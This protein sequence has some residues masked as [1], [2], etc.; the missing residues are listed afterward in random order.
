MADYETRPDERLE[1]LLRRWGAD[2]VVSGADVSG[3]PA[4]PLP[5]VR[6]GWLWRWMPL[7]A[8]MVLVAGA[9]SIF[10]ASHES[11]YDAAPA[12]RASL[13]EG[14]QIETLRAEAEQLRT[15]LAVAK[16]QLAA[17][18][19]NPSETAKLRA[20]LAKAK[21]QLEK[22]EAELADVTIRLYGKEN[23]GKNGQNVAA[24]QADLRKARSTLAQQRAWFKLEIARMSRAKSIPA[25]EMEKIIATRVNKALK[26]LDRDW[27]RHQKK[28]AELKKQLAA[29]SSAHSHN[30]RAFDFGLAQMRTQLAAV[31][32]SR[33]KM[34]TLL[35]TW[36]DAERNHR[37]WSRRVYLSAAAPGKQGY[38]ARQHAA[39]KRRLLERCAELRTK[40]SGTE[41]GDTLD[42]IE[43]LLTRLDLLDVHDEAA[44]DRFWALVKRAPLTVGWGSILKVPEP[45]RSE[46]GEWLLEAGLVLRE[47]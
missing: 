26:E 10:F 3:L 40:L 28:M 15:D 14:G 8:S 36:Q 45:A 44:G 46:F 5:A 29:E 34:A 18:E 12:P 22:S 37:A 30:R 24:L 17:M 1:H 32:E 11:S 13:A 39:R 35:D 2:E 41:Q 31:R 27:N 43:V 20:E 42:K 21:K 38:A 19:D 33:D 47:D 9:A 4:P 6:S 23:F 7:A 25:V 16:K